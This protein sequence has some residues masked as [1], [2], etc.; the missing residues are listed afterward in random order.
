MQFAALTSGSSRGMMGRKATSMIVDNPKRNALHVIGPNPC[1]YIFN[2]IGLTV[3]AAGIVYRHVWKNT[4]GECIVITKTLQSMV[5]SL[6]RSMLQ[7]LN[8]HSQ[9]GQVSYDS[10]YERF[11]CRVSY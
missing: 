4:N 5:F 9:L 8:L 6:N 11:S 2:T 3:R 10:E 1:T 7:S